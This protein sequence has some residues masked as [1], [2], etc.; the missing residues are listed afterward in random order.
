ML[1]VH[2]LSSAIKITPSF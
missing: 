1:L 2:F